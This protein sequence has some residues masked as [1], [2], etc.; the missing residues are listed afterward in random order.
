MKKKVS[1]ILKDFGLSDDQ[2]LEIACSERLTDGV[3]LLTQ[4]LSCVWNIDKITAM[5]TIETL[6]EELA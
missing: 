1:E 2:I 5:G 3:S 4:Y 6:K